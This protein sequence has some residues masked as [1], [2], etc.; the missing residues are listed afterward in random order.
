MKS[1][2]SGHIH[3]GKEKRHGAHHC[4]SYIHNVCDEYPGSQDCCQHAKN[5][6]WN[7]GTV[8]EVDSS[9]DNP[10]SGVSAISKECIGRKGTKARRPKLS[11][12][13]RYDKSAA[14]A[15]N[16][17][18]PPYP[19]KSLNAQ[20]EK[21][22][23]VLAYFTT[24]RSDQKAE[25]IAIERS[26]RKLL[27]FKRLDRVYD[28]QLRVWK[29][30]ESKKDSQQASD[31][32]FEVHREYD[33]HGKLE[34]TR[35]QINTEVLRT[36]L[37]HIFRACGCSI[38]ME[39]VFDV[40]PHILFHFRADI[41]A[42]LRKMLKHKGKRDKG[43]QDKEPSSSQAIQ[44]K[45][46]LDFI[47]EDFAGVEE[48]LGAMLRRG[49][50][51]YDLVWALFKPGTIAYTSTYQNEDD[52]RCF[53][54]EAAYECDEWVIDGKYLDCDGERFSM[55]HYRVAIQEFKGCKKITSLAAYPLQYR[56][57]SDVR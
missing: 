4:G 41:S 19:D 57:N 5:G 11:A 26:G 28:D 55:G 45:L 3:L 24:Q 42:Y 53:K 33:V 6:R 18:Q 30:V 8:D 38:A 7:H 27:E 35:V 47:T 48:K 34:K 9:S 36:A 25:G 16:P 52:P 51:S 44:C 10:S 21:F 43:A 15:D 32:V 39:G 1:K 54:V 12:S 22:R 56:K 14:Q 2:M 20:I 23:D 17:A 29:L 46:L 31:C 40:N 37:D 50:I 49:V 13:S